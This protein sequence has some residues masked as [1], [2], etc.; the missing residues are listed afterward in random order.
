MVMRA[1]AMVRTN[2]MPSTGLTFARGVP[3]IGTRLLMGTDSGALGR[4]ASWA[5]RAA[6]FLRVSPMPMMPPEQTLMPASRTCSRVSMRSSWQ[7]LL[8]TWP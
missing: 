5:M 8:I 1:A 7:W 6:R 4:L 2:S 3:G